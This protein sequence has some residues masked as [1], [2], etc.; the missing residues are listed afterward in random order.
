MDFHKEALDNFFSLQGVKKVGKANASKSSEIQRIK[1]IKDYRKISAGEVITRPADC[2]KELVENS[3]DAGSTQIT[4]II[5]NFAKDLIQVIDNGCGILEE[6]IEKAFKPHYSSKIETIDDLESLNSLGFRGEALS[7]ISAISKIEIIT[8][9]AEENAGIKCWIENGTIIKKEKIGSPVGTNIKII[10]LFYN[11]PIFKKYRRSDRIEMG[12]ITDI[13]TRMVL[14]YPQIHFK[15]M[16]NNSE[17]L[18]SPKSQSPL[19]V[20]L[21]IYGRNVAKNLREIN[22][23]DGEMEISGYLG[24]PSLARTSS[25]TSSVFVNKRYVK[26]P[27]IENAIKQAYKDY[28]MIN[29]RPFYIVFLKINPS[30]VDFN[31]HPTK[32]VIRFEN[33]VELLTKL[34]SYFSK[35]VEDN[36]GHKKFM[37]KSNKDLGE[38]Q[39]NIKDENL[40]GF[41]SI[42]KKIESTPMDCVI[43]SNKIKTGPL[44]DAISGKSEKIPPE[45][46]TKEDMRKKDLIKKN[47]SVRLDQIVPEL[48]NK[49]LEI[50]KSGINGDSHFQYILKPWIETGGI[51]PKMRVVNDA[52][53]LNNLYF[54][55]EGEDG[56]YI[57]DM[58]AASE[59]I[60]YEKQLELF[61]KGGIS[62]QTLIMPIKFDVT[63]NERDFIIENIPIIMKF[64]FEIENIGGNTFA[65]RAVPSNF[66]NLN[67]SEVIKDICMEI[68]TMGKQ[69][70][71]DAIY[72]RIIKYISCHMSLRGGE[73][74]DN[75]KRVKELLIELSKCSN[76]HHC[77]HGRPT[78]LFF[79]WENIDKQFHRRQ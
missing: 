39:K 19:N 42:Q 26:S 53:Q 49:D 31:I 21:D 32:K 36:F 40:V 74:I 44:M 30:S 14:A 56:F 73:Y 60:N 66:L 34:I 79:S 2:V 48:T 50:S 5:K 37:N 47:M 20:I 1:L 75:P 10:N 9:T 77:A 71:L 29:K 69:S 4:V 17:I 6:D 45:T 16:H 54:V 15:L 35:S 33:E 12:H 11:T 3:I 62:K 43:S 70:R 63:V 52:G 8:K 72:D 27:L 28:I 25:L 22:Y 76:P 64:G 13:I 24:D 41:I 58:H 59:R 23:S 61:S 78:M 57:L 51:F 18:N 55:L 38:I 68:I 7:A 67:D 46:S 65:I